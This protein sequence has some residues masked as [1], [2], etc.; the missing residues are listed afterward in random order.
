[1]SGDE[2]L[3]RSWI[4]PR[5]VLAHPEAGAWDADLG[6]LPPVERLLKLPSTCLS[7]PG[8]CRP[9]ERCIES[10][11]QEKGGFEA[12]AVVVAPD[13]IAANPAG[14]VPA[15]LAA[16]FGKLSESEELKATV[17]IR[18]HE[19]GEYGPI[20]DLIRTCRVAGFSRYSLRAN[21]KQREAR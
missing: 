11:T 20:Q 13:M 16:K 10:A 5:F 9:I 1:M 14:D 18:A 7:A 8:S 19:D 15:Q 21:L 12:H 4:S 2:A 3:A 17:V 6:K